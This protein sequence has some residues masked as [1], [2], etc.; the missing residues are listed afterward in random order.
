NGDPNV[1]PCPGIPSALDLLGLSEV[2]PT[3]MNLSCAK[4]ALAPFTLALLACTTAMI[5]G[6]VYVQGGCEL[7]GV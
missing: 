6:Y 4:E 2:Q 5:K 3:V 1:R 7:S